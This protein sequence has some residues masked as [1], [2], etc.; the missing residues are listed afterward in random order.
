MSQG[1]TPCTRHQTFLRLFF[2]LDFS[3]LAESWKG[4]PCYP[5]RQDIQKWIQVV[6]IPWSIANGCVYVYMDANDFS[7]SVNYGI[8]IKTEWSYANH[9]TEIF[10]YFGKKNITSTNLLIWEW[11]QSV[12]L[13]VH[14]Y[15][16]KK[17]RYVCF[18][19][20][21]LALPIRMQSEV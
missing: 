8:Y 4:L 15:T 11:V 16:V 7:K 17:M 12:R 9:E 13:I 5:L 6:P 14:D 2:F 10:M 18:F 19:I 3:F 1:S 20:Y 21:R